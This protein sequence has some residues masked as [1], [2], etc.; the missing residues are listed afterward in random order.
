MS[1]GGKGDK[2][3]PLAVSME[4]FDKSWETI[5]GNGKTLYKPTVFG[6]V[7]PKKEGAYWSDDPQAT[8]EEIKDAP[9]KG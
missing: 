1:H 7:A 5:F 4:K 3:R 9:T 2:P 6:G 8:I